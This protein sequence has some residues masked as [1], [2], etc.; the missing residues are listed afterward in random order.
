MHKSKERKVQKLNSCARR[1][2][3]DGVAGIYHRKSFFGGGICLSFLLER[4]VDSWVRV[5]LKHGCCIL[6]DLSS[7][8][9]NR[10]I[11]FEKLV[12]PELR[13]ALKCVL[14]ASF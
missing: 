8:T 1:A 11:S 9:T 12:E 4:L 5:L 6:L 13:E 3:F 2:H 7:L 14:H 10:G